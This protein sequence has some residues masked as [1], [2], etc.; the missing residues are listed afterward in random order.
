MSRKEFGSES[1]DC[2]RLAGT[3]PFMS[4][5][6]I[7]WA[8]IQHIG[9][10]F[11]K[12]TRYEDPIAIIGFKIYIPLAEM[13][14]KARQLAGQAVSLRAEKQTLSDKGKPAIRR[15][16]TLRKLKTRPYLNYYRRTTRIGQAFLAIESMRPK[17]YCCPYQGM[18]GYLIPGRS[19]AKDPKSYICHM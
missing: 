4:N 6:L 13:S 1:Y 14:S 7:M 16:E 10:D 5:P 8:Q 2:G 17:Q 11:Q 3:A 15:K 19:K 9:A 12:L 18:M